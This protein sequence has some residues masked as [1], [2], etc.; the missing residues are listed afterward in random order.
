MPGCFTTID[1]LSSWYCNPPSS[2]ITLTISPFSTTALSLAPKPVP[3]PTT[4]K[5]GAVS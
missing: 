2:I 4:S 1:V 5:S 3:I